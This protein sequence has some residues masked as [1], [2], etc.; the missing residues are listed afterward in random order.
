[1]SRSAALPSRWCRRCRR[2]ARRR[3][4]GF[5]ARA[6]A[7]ASAGRGVAA[8]GYHPRGG[9]DQDLEDRQARRAAAGRWSS[10][11]S[12]A[13]APAVAPARSLS[14]RQPPPPS[15]GVVAASW[16]SPIRFAVKRIRRAR[17]SRLRPTAGSWCAHGPARACA[18][19]SRGVQGGVEF[20]EHHLPRHR[21][22]GQDVR[23]Q[24]Q[25]ALPGSVAAATSPASSLPRSGSRLS[26][27][28]AACSATAA[29]RSPATETS[30]EDLGATRPG[31]SG[32]RVMVAR[33]SATAQHFVAVDDARQ[34]RSQLLAGRRRRAAGW[35]RPAP[36]CAA[37]RIRR[38]SARWAAA[39]SARCESSP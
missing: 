22:H 4:R 5:P 10:M 16:R 8:T 34:R 35:L 21:V 6:A 1:M 7:A 27:A 29:C 9:R 31:A 33:S 37:R 36:A 26:I 20:A 39:V 11:S 24:H 32:D 13:V 30:V 38:A 25:H 18:R 2:T 12:I 28:R 15:V 14:G 19:R 23:G 17:S 3:G